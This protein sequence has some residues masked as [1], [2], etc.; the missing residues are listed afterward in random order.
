MRTATENIFVSLFSAGH[1]QSPTNSQIDFHIFYFS[2]FPFMYYK[3]GKTVS[4][5]Q[6]TISQIISSDFNK[7]L[8]P[9]TVCRKK[10]R[11]MHIF[12]RVGQQE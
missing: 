3:I 11:M 10:M 8:Q 12:T 7:Y 9:H 1:S 6:L 2:F 5:P 4:C